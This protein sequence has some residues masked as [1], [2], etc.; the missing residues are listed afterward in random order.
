MDIKCTHST[1]LPVTNHVSTG[2][3][4]LKKLRQFH[5]HID[6]TF[7]HSSAKQPSPFT[8]QSKSERKRNI[9]YT[10]IYEEPALSRARFTLLTCGLLSRIA[11]GAN[12]S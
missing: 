8:I 2:Q 9:K 1:R 11:E 4:K 3:S 10:E 7:P 12:E 5:R 6:I